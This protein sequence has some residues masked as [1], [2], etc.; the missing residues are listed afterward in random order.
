MQSTGQMRIDPQG[1][2]VRITWRNE[3][4]MGGSPVN[5]WFG[6]FMDRLVGPDFEDGLRNLK[7]LVEG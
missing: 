3:G 6:L 7:A 5:R 2:G 4:D 1:S